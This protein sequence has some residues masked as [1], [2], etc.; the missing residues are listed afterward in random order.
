M[1]PKTPSPSTLR[2][3]PSMIP[4]L[5]PMQAFSMDEDAAFEELEDDAD[6]EALV[7]MLFPGSIV[8]R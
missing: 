7:E 1:A 4:S 2:K 8:P 6:L 5:I 3:N